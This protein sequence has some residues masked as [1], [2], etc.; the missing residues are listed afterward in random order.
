MKRN[1]SRSSMLLLSVLMGAL[2]FDVVLLASFSNA[3][4]NESANRHAFGGPF[5]LVDQNGHKVSDK[6]FR[7]KYMLV[8]FGYTHCPS[9]CPTTL[10]TYG[11]ILK[12]LGAEAK[13]TVPIFISVDSKRDTPAEMKDYLSN[14]DPSVV[15][16]TGT[17]EQ[18][19]ELARAYRV[20]YR[21]V[22]DE[23][24]P[25][26]YSIDHSAL[27]YMMG[28]NGEYLDRFYYDSPEDEIV[29]KIRQHMEVIK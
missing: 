10:L 21:V 20:K 18:I 22:N 27:V 7:G 19:K 17:P 6:D 13:N 5:T 24:A 23:N 28:K 8:F 26:G 29:H 14:F 2:A 25:D 12:K 3:H 15:G 11:N 9:A 1:L 16:L 4:A